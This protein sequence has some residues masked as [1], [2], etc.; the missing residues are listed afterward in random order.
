MEN[1]LNLWKEPECIAGPPRRECFR[2]ARASVI[3]HTRKKWV[4]VFTRG[5]V[6]PVF[7]PS[8]FN[9]RVRSTSFWI[10]SHG[11]NST[12]FFIRFCFWWVALCLCVAFSKA[13]IVWKDSAPELCPRGLLLKQTFTIDFVGVIHPLSRISAKCST[14]QHRWYAWEQDPRANGAKLENAS[15]CVLRSSRSMLSCVSWSE[16]SPGAKPLLR[17]GL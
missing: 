10:K 17:I 9:E 13:L 4:H 16:N 3:S 15:S 14:I 12:V 2:L 5:R 7:S 11:E 6:L 1:H 8:A